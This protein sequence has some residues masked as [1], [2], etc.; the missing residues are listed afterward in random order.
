MAQRCS[1]AK[2]TSASQLSTF[3]P[4]NSISRSRASAGKR[5][6]FQTARAD[7]T[8]PRVPGWRT[9]PPQQSVRAPA[10]S[11]PSPA[12]P[13]TCGAGLSPSSTAR[14]ALAGIQYLQRDPFPPVKGNIARRRV[15]EYTEGQILQC[16]PA[17]LSI[18]GAVL[19]PLFA[20]HG[21]AG[22]AGGGLSPLPRTLPGYKQAVAPG[23]LSFQRKEWLQCG[24]E[25]GTCLAH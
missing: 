11:F 24:G 10:C 15:L 22:A 9:L 8:V 12:A 14:L 13:A 3:A 4:E 2:G 21:G 6:V 25:L 5:Q 18:P 23:Q 7:R 20:R 19:P 1:I 17:P 16:L